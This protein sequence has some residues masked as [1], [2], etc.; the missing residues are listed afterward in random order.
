[1]TFKTQNLPFDIVEFSKHLDKNKT[2]YLINNAVDLTQKIMD[3]NKITYYT[4]KGFSYK[5][6]GIELYFEIRSYVDENAF[7]IYEIK[8]INKNI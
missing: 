7:S 3:E 5:D 6:K 8:K 1:M 2:N 4:G